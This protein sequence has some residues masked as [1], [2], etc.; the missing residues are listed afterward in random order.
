MLERRVSG[1]ASNRATMW[2]TAN[3]VTV[4]GVQVRLDTGRAFIFSGF[5]F[6]GALMT[7]DEALAVAEEFAPTLAVINAKMHAHLQK[8]RG[9]K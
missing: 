9:A 4:I 6:A 5:P 8:L 1:D 3:G 2:E 7:E